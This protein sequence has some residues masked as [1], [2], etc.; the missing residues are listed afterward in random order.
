MKQTAL[1][2]T[3]RHHIQNPIRDWYL[4]GTVSKEL[5]GIGCR[6]NVFFYGAAVLNIQVGLMVHT[7]RSPMVWWSVKSVLAGEI[8]VVLGVRKL[9]LGT[10]VDI[11]CTS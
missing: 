5:L 9:Q 2:E 3:H 1:K 4:V 7:Q 6:T 11:T 10:V 8:S